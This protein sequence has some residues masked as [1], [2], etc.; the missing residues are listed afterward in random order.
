ML[1]AHIYLSMST[2]CIPNH[3]SKQ[4]QIKTEGVQNCYYYSIIP[5]L[6]H[7]VA[8]RIPILDYIHDWKYFVR[9]LIEPHVTESRSMEFTKQRD[10]LTVAKCQVYV[11]Y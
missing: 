10:S 8:Y 3:Q 6:R 9:L 1:T 7:V 11:I 2:F 5:A 4:T